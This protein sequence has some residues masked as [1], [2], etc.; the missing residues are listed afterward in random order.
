MK[1][2]RWIG[3]PCLSARES[4][5]KN[6]LTAPNQ[7]GA[8]LHSRGEGKVH[9]PPSGTGTSCARNRI[10]HMLC[11]SCITAKLYVHS[12]KHRPNI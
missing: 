11:V 9:V 10:L 3:S 2:T 8:P 12:L 6:I 4:V 7:K 5:S 1:G